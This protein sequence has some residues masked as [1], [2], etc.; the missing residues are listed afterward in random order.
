MN[1]KSIFAVLLALGMALNVWADGAYF[2]NTYSATQT[3]T[4]VTITD[5]GSGG[6]S[7]AFL[8]RSLTICSD[9]SAAGADTCYF[10]LRD[11]T[12]TTSDWP[13]KPGAC[14]AKVWLD[15]NA[16]GGWAGLGIICGTGD[17][18]TITVYAS[19]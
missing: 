17:T 3:N 5:N 4:A 18:A 16:G 2:N 6:T 13:I 12:A 11:T 8:A 19:R 1:R 7:A 15:A 9:A 10:D 14:I